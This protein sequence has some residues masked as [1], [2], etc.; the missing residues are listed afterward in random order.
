MTAQPVTPWENAEVNGLALC[1]PQVLEL[2]MA[3][4]QKLR[5]QQDQYMA[6]LPTSAEDCLVAALRILEADT[7]GEGLQEAISLS[8]GVKALAAELTSEFEGFP[9][10][11][12]LF[13]AEKLQDTLLKTAQELDRARDIL[14]NPGRLAVER[15]RA[16]GLQ[17]Q[18]HSAFSP[19]ELT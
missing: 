4:V 7:A 5:D 6:S 19:M 14:G 13:L 16:K 9:R 3:K 12:L 10:S 11:S 18:G 1:A 2:N 8:F 17:T 15:N